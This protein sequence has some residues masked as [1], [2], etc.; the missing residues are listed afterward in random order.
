MEKTKALHLASR[1]YLFELEA[2]ASFQVYHDS[3]K[4]HFNRYQDSREK[5]ETI[6]FEFADFLDTRLLEKQT[7]NKIDVDLLILNFGYSDKWDAQYQKAEAEETDE[8]LPFFLDQKNRLIGGVCSGLA[9]YFRFDLTLF[10]I[11]TVIATIVFLP[12]IFF[13]IALWIFGPSYASAYQKKHAN[14]QDNEVKTNVIKDIAVGA[15]SLISKIIGII[16]VIVAVALTLAVIALIMLLIDQQQINILELRVFETSVQNLFVVSLF[17]AILFP[18]LMIFLL[19]LRL[20]R[21]KALPKYSWTTL[22]G[23]WIASVGF[24][25]VHSSDL[26]NQF[27]YLSSYQSDIILSKAN[28]EHIEIQT[29]FRPNENRYDLLT[30]EVNIVSSP[31]HDSVVIRV[32]YFSSGS[33]RK[34]ARENAE[35]IYFEPIIHGNTIN[36]D[37]TIAFESNILFRLQRVEVTI[38]VPKYSSVKVTNYNRDFV[39]IENKKFSY[40]KRYSGRFNK[41]QKLGNDYFPAFADELYLKNS[42]SGFEI[43]SH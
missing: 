18:F 8:R 43:E 30:P 15:S 28:S 5:V 20:I 38:Y 22:F 17:V 41:N 12:L 35:T 33:S 6:E 36:I 37:N 32:R 16:F 9:I 1:V 2:F 3:L 26:S 19:G 13:Y 23:L 25:G 11:L 29:N 31:R 7:I 34:S 24:L 40:A 21:N 4:S 27:D 42:K 10:R 14:I 39:F